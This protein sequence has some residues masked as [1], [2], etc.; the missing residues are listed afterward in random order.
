MSSSRPSSRVVT[1]L[2]GW[3]LRARLI[4]ALV[5]LLA[6]ACVTVGVA[7]EVAVSR[8]QLAQL[9]GQLKSAADRTPH[10]NGPE[11]GPGPLPGG[12]RGDGPGPPPGTLVAHITGGG[13]ISGW[14]ISAN[15]SQQTLTDSQLAVLAKL[16]EDGRHYTRTVGADD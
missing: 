8:I 3:S 10:D 7:S 2:R 11:H 12:L 1:W 6:V 16:P 5:A 9:D 4:A 13:A 15:G 14:V